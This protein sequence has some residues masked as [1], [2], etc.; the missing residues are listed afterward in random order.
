MPSSSQKQ[1]MKKLD[2]NVSPSYHEP[3]TELGTGKC[4]RIFSPS[5]N[6]QLSGDFQTCGSWRTDTIGKNQTPNLWFE[7]QSYR[8]S[9]KGVVELTGAVRKDFKICLC[10]HG[11]IMTNAEDNFA[12]YRFWVDRCLVVVVGFSSSSI[13]KMLIHCLLACRV[14]EESLL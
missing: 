9:E 5:E 2:L 1:P 6:Y 8:N 14:S 11:D 13:L 12:G 4:S 7:D 10:S 3:S